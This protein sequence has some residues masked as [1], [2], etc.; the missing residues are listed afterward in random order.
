MEKLKKSISIMCVSLSFIVSNNSFLN[1]SYQTEESVIRTVS[2]ANQKDINIEDF[3][4]SIYQKTSYGFEKISTK[5]FDSSIFK[6]VDLVSDN[7]SEIEV[8]YEVKYFE[9]EGRVTLDMFETYKKK[10][11]F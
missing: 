2:Y 1:F 9:A 11:L 6:N 10:L 5:K 4:S 8:T 7:E 3:N